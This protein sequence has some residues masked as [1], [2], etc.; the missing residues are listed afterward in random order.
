MG[1]ATALALAGRFGQSLTMP[2][3]PPLARPLIAV[4][5]LALVSAVLAV[6]CVALAFAWTHERQVTACWRAAAEFQL[7]PN[8]DC[9]GG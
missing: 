8:G 1:S 5:I 3:G 4:R 2:K 9:D 7:M 6:I